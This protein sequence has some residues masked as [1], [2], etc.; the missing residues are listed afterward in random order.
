MYVYIYIYI[1]RFLMCVYHY[2]LDNMISGCQPL[3]DV[4]SI[5]GMITQ[6]DTKSLDP[7][8]IFTRKCRDQDR[9]AKCVYLPS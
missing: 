8:G 4:S 6:S 9:W 1:Y 3:L 5:L 2:P 7:L